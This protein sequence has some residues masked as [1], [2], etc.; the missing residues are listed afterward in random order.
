MPI[1]YSTKPQFTIEDSM[2][3]QF[4][5][6][7]TLEN[8][9]Q[10]ILTAAINKK[11]PSLSIDL[12]KT[13]LATPESTGSWLLV[14]LMG[15]VMDYLANGTA[16]DL[17]PLYS[18]P[19]KLTDGA[20]LELGSPSDNPDMKVIEGLI[21]ELPWIIP[22][23]M[24]N[25]LMDYWTQAADTG[26]S[27]WRWVSDVLRDTLSI[28]AARQDDLSDF[29]RET[30]NQ[31]IQCPENEEQIRRFGE[32]HTRVLCLEITL[33]S[34][35][36]NATALSSTFVL[37]RG[38]LA[39]QCPP[40]GKIA[41]FSS[42]DAVFEQL[43]RE[44]AEKYSVDE[45]LINRYVVDGNIFDAQAGV[46]LNRQ[47]HTL[48]TLKLPASIGVEALEVLSKKLTDPTSYFRGAPLA[49]RQAL[50]SL[51]THL[52][53]WLL[54]ACPADKALYRHY[55]L[56][57]ARVKKAKWGRNFLSGISDIRQFAKTA[58]WIKMLSDRGRFEPRSSVQT[59]SDLNIDDIEL[60]FF[61]FAASGGSIGSPGPVSGVV[62]PVTMSLTDLALKN[63][64][65]SPGSLATVRHRL[66][67]SLPAWLTPEYVTG[68]IQQVDIGR[69]YPQELQARLLGDT[70]DAGERERLFGDQLSAQLPLQAL[71][72]S[73][74]KEN[75][76]T[77]L[78]VR[79]VAALMQPEGVVQQVGDEPVV[80]RHLALLREPDATPD[81]VSNMFIIEP[82]NIE[83]GPHLLYRPFYSPVLH[84]F[85]SRAALLE[86]ISNPGP[87]QDSV[88]VWLD[89]SARSVYANG[90]FHEPHFVRYG[91]GIE[92]APIDLTPPAA[93]LSTSDSNDELQ[94]YLQNGKLHQYLYGSNARALVEQADRDSVSNSENRWAALFEGGSL[95]FNTLLSPPFLGG[96]VMVT[97]WL[98]S[99][100]SV[101]KDIPALYSEDPVAREL[102]LVDLLL[103]VGMSLFH[104]GSSVLQSQPRLAP[105]TRAKVVP[106]PAPLTIA[107]QLPEPLLPKVVT[108]TVSLAGE[109]PKT[110][111]MLLDFSFASARNRLTPS[112]REN[113]S[114]FEVM[115]EGPLPDPIPDGMYV[116]NGKRH[117]M[118]ENQLYQ[119]QDVQDGA[120]AI[121]NP[122][123]VN[124]QGPYL[125]RSNGM[126]S[127][128]LRLGLKGGAPSKRL[129]ALALANVEKQNELATFAKKFNEE[130][131][132][133]EEKYEKLVTLIKRAKNDPRKPFSEEQI[134]QMH[135]KLS[136]I[137]QEQ[138]NLYESFLEKALSLFEKS[139]HWQ[140]MAFERSDVGEV[141]N[142]LARACDAVVSV[143][144]LGRVALGKAY[145]EFDIPMGPE[146]IEVIRKNHAR[147]KELSR[148]LT[149]LDKSSLAMTD[150]K[151]RFLQRREKLG[152][153]GFEGTHPYVIAASSYT[154]LGMRAFILRS[155]LF[156]GLKQWHS[157]A[158]IMLEAVFEPLQEHIQTHTELNSINLGAAERLDVLGS[159]VERYGEAQDVMANLDGQ[160]DS[161][162]SSQVNDVL[163]FLKQ[164]AFS[165]LS[166]EIEQLEWVGQQSASPAKSKP[167]LQV[168]QRRVI[169]TRHKGTLIGRLRPLVREAQNEM[170][171]IRSEPD[172]KLLST[173][174]KQGDI[175]EEVNVQAPEPQNIDI[176]VGNA[177]KLA[178]EQVDFL[179]GLEGFK[180][181]SE[182]A[183]AVEE[184]ADHQAQRL[185]EA[186]RGL[187]N[188]L[189]GALDDNEARYQPLIDELVEKS[190]ALRAKGLEFRKELSLRLPPTHGNLQ[191]LLE[192]KF[193]QIHKLGPRQKM[194]RDFL[195][196]YALYE[197]DKGLADAPWYAH[198]H[199][200]AADTPKD[201]YTAAH[202]KTREQRRQGTYATG[203]EAA[204]VRINVYRGQIGS[205]LIH[206]WFLPLAT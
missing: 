206:Q 190:K 189:K 47:L 6:R 55:S 155:K 99:L 101:V 18:W 64:S 187:K 82:A 111:S 105:G 176:L 141:V 87:L 150:L 33:S 5:T 135:Q 4:A 194:R 78:G 81:I 85:S 25:A 89:D 30:I 174:S 93:S 198:F 8:V 185:D 70:P 182:H 75:G 163:K 79:Y 56:E 90:G 98:L 19:Q 16:L 44:V 131:P 144:S 140:R 41:V 94:T 77:P 50:D 196:E 138:I 119:V 149:K 53:E 3:A 23:G 143:N 60:I 80:I 177:R 49:D 35:S 173:Y 76:L 171:E 120:V 15:R 72:L 127:L 51:K 191:F 46:V 29:A 123:N 36:P 193:L 137:A 205:N 96:P 61:K 179:K 39:L 178:A 142:K 2:R 114:R 166:V 95:I 118:V 106:L 9:T 170:V 203:T 186:A 164:D 22:V 165:K 54:Q 157:A 48:G 124:Q 52:P 112:Q 132:R 122:R 34:D 27:R 188:A 74:K 91:L 151:E 202:L 108:G 192:N 175:W 26:L 13:W 73:L 115:V 83:A 110:H 117:V 63:L 130:S 84:E 57:L 100:I 28:H 183:V 125:Q 7:P 107:K 67:L 10:Q 121:V 160:L 11:Y 197:T 116:I 40:A 180:Q 152:S 32:D 128:D 71:E 156:Q 103:N 86:A 158:R 20:G 168:T 59:S 65:G 162:V 42:M 167:A 147:Y 201:A 31:V 58:L 153:S 195:Q 129:G 21:K 1:P 126:W 145:P 139:K 66:G 181:V 69:V 104:V 184:I 43:R 17:G 88:L 45:V 133:L 146:L 136:P 204:Q 14:P 97:A 12:A 169:K 172:N 62:E 154:P 37:T 199:Y 134:N 113:L 38:N 68:L 161:D 200:R 92:Y 24:Q 109:L 102:A 148:E 159:L